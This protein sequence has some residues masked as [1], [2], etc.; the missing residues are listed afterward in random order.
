MRSSTN[1]D[2]AARAASAKPLAYLATLAGKAIRGDFNAE[3]RPSSTVAT[4]TQTPSTPA[5]TPFTN[6]AERPVLTT[7][8]LQTANTALSALQA[9]LDPRRRKEAIDE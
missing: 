7:A 2:I 8:N 5:T 1:G 3:W 6:P 9:F 4:P